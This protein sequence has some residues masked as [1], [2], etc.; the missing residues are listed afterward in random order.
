MGLVQNGGPKKVRKRKKTQKTP[1]NWKWVDCMKNIGCK[2]SDRCS[3]AKILNHKWTFSL[4]FKSPLCV[5]V[6]AIWPEYVE[7]L[8]SHT[9][10]QKWV[11]FPGFWTTIW[12]RLKWMSGTDKYYFSFYQPTFK[13]FS[14]LLFL[15]INT[16]N[17]IVVCLGQI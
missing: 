3:Q 17:L 15:Y 10:M 4:F 1:N 16:S 13:H 6:Q 7:I 9:L 2:L 8:D 5:L 11:F 14:Y 12:K